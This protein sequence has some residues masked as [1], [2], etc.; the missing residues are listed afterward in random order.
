MKQMGFPDRWCLWIKGIL[1]S[2]RSSVLVN[3]SPTF[4]FQCSKGLRQGDPISP[5]LFIMVM[6]VLS[7]MI[8]KARSEEVVTGIQIPNGP[9]VSHLFYADDAIILGEWSELNIRNVVRILRVFNI[10]SGLRINLEKSNIFAV[11][12][13]SAELDS[14][15]NC[16]G[17]L[18]GS[19]P[20]KYLGLMVGANMNRVCNWK[21]VYDVFDARLAKWKAKLLSVGG[22]IT[23]IKATIEA[24]HSVRNGGVFLPAKKSLSGVWYNIAPVLCKTN[25][26]GTP[27]RSFFKASVGNGSSTAFWLDP[28]VCNRPLK[29]AFPALFQLE[30]DKSCKVSVCFGLNQRFIWRWRRPLSSETEVNEL[31][32]LCSLM[33]QVTLSQNIDK[34]E[35]IGAADKEFSVKAVKKLLDSDR[36]GLENY[37]IEDC[38]WIP[39]KCSIFIW[40]AEMGRIATTD[41]LR[42]RNI[43]VGDS[44]CCL[45]GE[46]NE[47]IEHIF[48]G[49]SVASMLW[50]F[51][52]SWCKCQNFMIFSFRDLIEV[53][54]HVGLSGQKIEVVKGLIH[55]G[56]WSLWKIRNEARFN[57]KPGGLLSWAI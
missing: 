16:V 5:F 21:P 51:I 49:C 45:C 42:K 53:H 32:N 18:A 36:L 48:T 34:W 52:S 11:G 9:C 2:A 27:L 39:K 24:L 14:M 31:V 7:C 15:A 56:C 30:M 46:V 38:K 19:F 23:L 4:E 55:I 33:V 12:V 41:E 22:R 13:P 50:S 35:W 26:N 40:K 8:E 47:S 6:E 10:C 1:E 57:N 43:D 3:G 17:C 37:V 54:N 28:W 20:F 25:I 44:G 29:E